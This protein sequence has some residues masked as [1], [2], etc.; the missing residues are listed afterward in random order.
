M[1]EKKKKENENFPFFVF[2][3]PETHTELLK[4]VSE[5]EGVLPEQIGTYLRSRHALYC[6]TLL[7]KTKND[8]LTFWA[9]NSMPYSEFKGLITTAMS[10]TEHQVLTTSDEETKRIMKRIQ[11]K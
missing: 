8:L 3:N 9:N 7:A 5:T 10:A 6:T 1:T 4:V 11:P 2:K